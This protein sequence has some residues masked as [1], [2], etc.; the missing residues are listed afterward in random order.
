[1]SRPTMLIVLGVMV[2]LAPFSGLPMA[3]LTWIL[4]LLGLVVLAIGISM[5]R[6]Q[7]ASIAARTPSH[8][9]TVISA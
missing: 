4:P 7:K 1:M 3:I 9:T 2:L 8:E 6:E 5:H